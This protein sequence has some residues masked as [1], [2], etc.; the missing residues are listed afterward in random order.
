MQIV[1]YKTHA[2]PTKQLIILKYSAW[3]GLQGRLSSPSTFI[4]NLSIRYTY[5]S[6][7]FI[8]FFKN[9]I[10]KPS[11]SKNAVRDT[12]YKEKGIENG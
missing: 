3:D 6:R 12:C 5:I 7:S 10:Y 9:V 11:T 2:K 1:S 4:K 8:Y